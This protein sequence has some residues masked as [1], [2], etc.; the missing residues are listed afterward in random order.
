[1]PVPLTSILPALIPPSSLLPSMLLVLVVPVLLL[2]VPS[3]E[4]LP[5]APTLPSIPVLSP[6][7]QRSRTFSPRRPAAEL[8]AMPCQEPA[9]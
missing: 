9:W 3:P 8:S 7:L 5:S 1:M 6:L 4:T 2:Q